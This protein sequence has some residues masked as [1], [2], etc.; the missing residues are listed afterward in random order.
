MTEFDLFKSKY[1]EALE[2]NSAERNPDRIFIAVS[3]SLWNLISDEVESF[4]K[5]GADRQFLFT[6]KGKKPFI[7]VVFLG[8][9]DLGLKKGR[10][11]GHT[12]LD[13]L[14]KLDK[15]KKDL[16]ICYLE[17]ANTSRVGQVVHYGS[18]AEIEL[19]LAAE[20][21]LSMLS[22]EKRTF[23]SSHVDFGHSQDE[24]FKAVK[25]HLTELKS[26]CSGEEFATKVM[27]FVVPEMS[28][29]HCYL[30]SLAK[31]AYLSS[32]QADKAKSLDSR[33]SLSVAS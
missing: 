20:L 16:F 31:Q 14:M 10:L 9:R 8:V 1:T 3:T 25:L 24:F 17:K 23:H 21:N 6:T 2:R 32:G 7:G 30:Y 29:L 11:S 33:I 26:R 12:G 18:P 19:D 27:S 22:F 4:F 28:G 5:G 13:V 15:T